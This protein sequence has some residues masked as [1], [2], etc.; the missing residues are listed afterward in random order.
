MLSCATAAQRDRKIADILRL[1]RLA[2]SAAARAIDADSHEAFLKAL[3]FKGAP[4]RGY[5]QKNALVLF[6]GFPCGQAS[7]YVP[8]A[9][10]RKV[11]YGKSIPKALEQLG[12]SQAVQFCPAEVALALQ[13]LARV[14]K[15]KWRVGRRVARPLFDATDIPPQLCAWSQGK[16]GDAPRPNKTILAG[17]W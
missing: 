12:L 6:S 9:G 15:E 16:Y 11:P 2:V 4:R 1:A 5:T 8:P 13:P 14:V 3:A 17:R 7:P 10:K